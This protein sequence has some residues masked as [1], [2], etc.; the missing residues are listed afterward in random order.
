MLRDGDR[1]RILHRPITPLRAS[2]A[3]DW[4]ALSPIYRFDASLYETD[5]VVVV[6]VVVVGVV[7]AG[8]VSTS[9]TYLTY[10]ETGA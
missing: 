8:H 10:N 3:I 1:G 7:R 4:I 6:V 9:G 2:S 5:K